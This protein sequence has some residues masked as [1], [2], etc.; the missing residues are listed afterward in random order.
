MLISPV[1]LVRLL[2][3]HEFGM[4]REFLVY[5]SVLASI[6]GFGVNSSLLRFVPD[7]PQTGWRYVDQV[8]A[9]TFASSLVVTAAALSLNSL[10]GGAVLG[11]YALR[12]ALYVLLFV[13][14]DFWEF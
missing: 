14:L 9:L 8:A 2:S 5:V 1:I 4:Y 7:D 10:T 6:A 12:V 11:D 3:V 13:N